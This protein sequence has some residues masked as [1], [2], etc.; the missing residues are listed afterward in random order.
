MGFATYYLS[1]LGVYGHRAYVITPFSSKLS[2]LSK[3]AGIE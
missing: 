3:Q 1:D 2:S